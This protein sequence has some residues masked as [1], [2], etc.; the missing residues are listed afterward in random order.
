MPPVMASKDMNFVFSVVADFPSISLN[1]HP[2][3]DFITYHSYKIKDKSTRNPQKIE[4][5]RKRVE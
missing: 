1:F 4:N 2:L 3:S 5:N